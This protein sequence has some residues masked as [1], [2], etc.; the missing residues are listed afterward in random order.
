MFYSRPGSVELDMGEV[1]QRTQEWIHDALQTP[2]AAAGD[3]AAIGIANERESVVVWDRRSGQSVARSITWQDTRTAAAADALTADR[4]IDRFQSTTGLP[5]STYSSA[6]SSSG[7][8]SIR[9]HRGVPPRSGTTCCSE[10]RHVLLWNLTGGPDGGVRDGPD[11]RQPHTADEPAQ[12]RMARRPAR[13]DVD[14]TRAALEIRSSSV[15]YGR[16]RSDLSGVPEARRRGRALRARGLGRDGRC[17]HPTAARQPRPDRRGAPKSRNCRGRSRTRV[18]SSS[19]R[20]SRGSSP[21]TGATT[22]AV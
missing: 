5:I 6:R 14:P 22:R 19:F 20:R 9:I 21:R 11:E 15:V 13:G 8:C 12:A 18:A 2:G 17:A 4:G 10:R 7:G 3:V 1:W 16:G